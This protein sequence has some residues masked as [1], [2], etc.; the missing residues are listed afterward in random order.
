MMSVLLLHV[1][2][3]LPGLLGPDVVGVVVGVDGRDCVNVA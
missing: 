1:L 2:H 3:G